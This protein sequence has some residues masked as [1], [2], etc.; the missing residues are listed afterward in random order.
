VGHWHRDCHT[1][2]KLHAPRAMRAE[3]AAARIRRRQMKL[4]TILFLVVFCFS[5][6]AET[7]QDQALKG[8]KIIDWKYDVSNIETVRASFELDNHSPYSIKDIKITCAPKGESG[9]EIK[10]ITRTVYQII[11][12]YKKKTT[13]PI[14][15]GWMP[16]QTRKI[17]CSVTGGVL[18]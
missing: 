4:C 14:D 6:A 12:P 10:Q 1:A 8:L 2:D 7:T 9:T 18:R 17:T 13:E 15:F 11:D 16:P 3:R 5:A